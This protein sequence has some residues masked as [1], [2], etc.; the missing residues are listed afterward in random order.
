MRVKKVVTECKPDEELLHKLG[1]ARREVEHQPSKGDVCNFLRKNTILFALID[2]D[3]ASSQPKY[4]S[5]FTLAEDNF[6]VKKLVHADNHQTIVILKPRLEEWIY[7]QCRDSKINPED[8]Y[9][10]AGAK[11]F[12]DVINKRV[13]HYSNLLSALLEK[14]NGGMLHLKKVLKNG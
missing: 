1:F 9:L 2:E 4:L 8:F 3:P 13:N 7:K 10:P 14:K 6:D 11:D 5:E 12:K